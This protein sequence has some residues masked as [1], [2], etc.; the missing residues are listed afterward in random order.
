MKP[1]NSLQFTIY[2]S[3]DNFSAW[4]HTETSK[5]DSFQFQMPYGGTIEIQKPELERY[6]A[7]IVCRYHAIREITLDRA[8]K[9]Y[10]DQKDTLNPKTVVFGPDKELT[11]ILTENVFTFIVFPIDQTGNLKIRAQCWC[12]CAFAGFSYIL[13]A[14]SDAYPEVR[15]TMNKHQEDL[16]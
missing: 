1:V 13:K 5:I 14:I 4:L 9:N 15:T 10:S 2:A 3:P 7:R 11:G 16:L 6:H 8:M 12:D